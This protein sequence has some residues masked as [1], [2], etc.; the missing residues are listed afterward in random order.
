ME[1]QPLNFAQHNISTPDANF[2]DRILYSYW[3]GS[4]TTAV[5]FDL[6][7]DLMPEAPGW[8]Q[9]IRSRVKKKA[10]VVREASL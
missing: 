8:G 2:L 3:L 4:R 6:R 7:T 5:S 9:Q 1:I 10:A